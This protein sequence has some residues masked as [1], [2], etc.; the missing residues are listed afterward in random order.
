M[1]SYQLR[2]D[3]FAEYEMQH[4][5]DWYNDKSENLGNDA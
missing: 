4:A 5:K 2:I 1:N 3:P